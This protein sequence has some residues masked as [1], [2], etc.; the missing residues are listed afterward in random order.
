MSDHFLPFY[1][2]IWKIKKIISI[3]EPWSPGGAVWLSM[4]IG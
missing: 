2:F 3:I 1:G 4:L